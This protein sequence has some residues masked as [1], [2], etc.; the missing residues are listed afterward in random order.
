MPLVITTTTSSSTTS[1]TVDPPVLGLLRFDEAK[2]LQSY[3]FL[4]GPEELQ[5]VLDAVLDAMGQQ[6]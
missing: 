4:Q 3:L 5:Q 2:N 1:P 6:P